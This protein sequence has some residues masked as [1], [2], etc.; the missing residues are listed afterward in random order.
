MAGV[1]QMS[2]AASIAVHASLWMART[3][4]RLTRS[5]EICAIFTFSEAHFAKV[6]Q[7]LARAGVVESVRGPRGG[8]R[9]ARPPQ[10]ITLLEVYEALDGP[11]NDDRCL[12]SPKVC[13]ARCCPIGREI[14]RL[15]RE[16]RKTLA[17]ATLFAMSAATDWSRF[18]NPAAVPPGP[19]KKKT[20]KKKEK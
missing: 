9:L 4:K 19:V 5:G 13:T 1:I 20:S 17:G 8:T 15:N 16:L 12:L 10:A 7:A 3:P 18:E 11:F 6:M 14:T 2:E